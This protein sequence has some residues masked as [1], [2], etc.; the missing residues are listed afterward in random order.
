MAIESDECAHVILWILLVQI[1]Y[2]PWVDRA[3]INLKKGKKT[4]N[5]ESA[6]GYEA[7]A[8][9]QTISW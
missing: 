6:R 3:K 9:L 4:H 5:F 7:Q 8:N 2:L 1:K